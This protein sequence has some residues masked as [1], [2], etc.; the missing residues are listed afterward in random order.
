MIIMSVDLGLARTG[1]AV[2]DSGESFAFPKT[3]IKEYNEERLVERIATLA[4]EYGAEQIVVGYP[5]NMNGSEGDRAQKCAEL[6]QKIGEKSQ[7]ETVLWD[8][9]CTTVSAHTALNFTDTR[10][11]KRKEVIDSVAAVIILEDYLRYKK[12][13]NQS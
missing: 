9:R 5:K 10:G 8:E 1:I 6:A 4:E 2:S 12:N 13:T 7:R 11:K 3:V